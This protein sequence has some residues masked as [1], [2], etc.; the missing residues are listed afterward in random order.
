MSGM[1]W[2]IKAILLV[3]LF[4]INNFK[5]SLASPETACNFWVTVPLLVTGHTHIS[6]LRA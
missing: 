1:V 2:R 6:S 3:L 5:Q 4:I